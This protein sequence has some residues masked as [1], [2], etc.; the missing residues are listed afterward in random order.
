M[1]WMYAIAL[2]AAI[3]VRSQTLSD[4]IYRIDPRLACHEFEI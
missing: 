2:I 4:S 3:A 1:G